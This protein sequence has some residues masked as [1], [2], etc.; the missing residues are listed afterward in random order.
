MVFADG[1]AYRDETFWKDNRLNNAYI[2]AYTE[3]S[4]NDVDITKESATPKDINFKNISTKVVEYIKSKF[5]NI[6]FII[7]DDD[8]NEIAD[9]L[10]ILD[11]R[12]ILVHNK[13]SSEEE[14]GLRVDDVQVVIAQLLKNIRFFLPVSY[15]NKKNRLWNNI[16]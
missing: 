3:I 16:I 5:D 10:V 1:I 2:K 12:I 13:F 14:S 6:L 9:H 8:A 15:D 4:W 7:Q 11:N